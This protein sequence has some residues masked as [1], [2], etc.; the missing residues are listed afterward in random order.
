MIESFVQQFTG[1]PG[2]VD[3]V[4]SLTGQGRA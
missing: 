3:V 4:H 1:S 2:A